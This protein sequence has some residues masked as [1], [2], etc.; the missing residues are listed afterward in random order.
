MSES[1]SLPDEEGTSSIEPE[2]SPAETTE[3]TPGIS[4]TDEASIAEMAEEEGLP[5]ASE[6]PEPTEEP[7]APMAP[8]PARRG[9][10]GFWG[11]L[12]GGVLAAVI[13]FGAAQFAG[14]LDLPFLNNR[15]DTGMAETLA[16]QQERLTALSAEVS[17]LSDA[18]AAAESRDRG[19]E[20][21][22]RIAGLE[23]SL[24]DQ[25]EALKTEF[26]G[27]RDELAGFETRL[28]TLEKRPVAETGDISGAVAAY[29][30]ELD[31]MRSELV[32]QRAQN[33][34]LAAGITAAAESASAEIDAAAQR[35]HELEERGAMMRILA[36]LETGGG[37]APALDVL[38]GRDVPAAL[39]AAADGVPT[40]A[41]LKEQFAEPARAALDASLRVEAGDNPGDR[42]SA[43][44]R[45]QVG[46]RSLTP[47]EGNDP[48]A[49]LSRAE[50]AVA[51]G[52][53]QDALAEIAALPDEGQAEMAGWVADAK[54]RI[55]A[56]AAAKA[57]AATMNLN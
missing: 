16:G 51:E 54:T 42:L 2:E 49:I 34:E 41:A 22:D 21:S 9:R 55:E 48:D 1:D 14:P 28:T 57:L 56:V 45:A 15:A 5:P 10:V 6:E 50:A 39:S 11:T 7:V 38:S 18:V 13:G 35:A 44:L 12:L 29:E 3:T 26:G 4:E 52:R 17:R 20:L 27:V 31:A 25:I 46:A 24:T 23:T 33:A 19:A 40:I 36:S 30:R 37:F 8:P 32:A 43:F 47:R 53:L